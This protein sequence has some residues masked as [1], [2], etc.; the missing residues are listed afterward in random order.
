[1][2]YALTNNNLLEALKNLTIKE[3]TFIVNEEVLD[4]FIKSLRGTTEA[5]KEDYYKGAK[6][7]IEYCKENGINE[8]TEETITSYYNSLVAR[9]GKPKEEKGLTTNSVNLYLVALRKLYKYLAKKGVKNIASDLKSVKTTRDYKKDV[10]TKSQALDLLNSIDRTTEVGK[11]NYALI[12]LLLYTGLRTIEVERAKIEDLRIKGTKQVLQVQGKGHKE[13]DDYI[14]LNNIVYDAI[15]DYLNARKNIKPNDPL[16]ISY[17]D[18]SNG[19][20]LKTRTIRDIVKKHLRAIGIN[21]TRISSHSLRHTAITYALLGGA[22][23]QE[24][25]LLARHSNINTTLIYAHNIDK[26]NNNYEDKINNY[27]T[28]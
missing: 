1:M 13:K 3:N 9:I 2:D 8:A 22:T 6:N 10:L 11:R 17:S 12:T 28:S 4:D 15:L 26:L 19:E 27:L 16:F 25:Q 20:T 7:F 14:K 23:L 21:T 18:R 24:A 5:T